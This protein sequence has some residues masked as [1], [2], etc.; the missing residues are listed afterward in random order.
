[1]K[2]KLKLLEQHAH[3]LLRIMLAAI[4]FYHGIQAL[5][6]SNEM[7]ESLHLS[8]TLFTLV[9]IAEIGGA[10]LILL[11]GFLYDWMTRLGAL[12]MGVVMIGAMVIVHWGQ[13][14]FL[15]SADHPAGGIEFPLTILVI[16]IY[17]IIRG[18]SVNKV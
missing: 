2:D 16:S 1:M 5:P 13:W 9:V 6:M 14:S 10:L 11:G 3:W 7:A 12:F 18:N 8:S 17:F 4:F 15:P